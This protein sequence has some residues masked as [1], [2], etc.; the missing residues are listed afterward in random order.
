MG[1]SGERLGSRKGKAR[2]M[3][4]GWESSDG[5]EGHAQSGWNEYVLFF[6]VGLGGQRGNLHCNYTQL[7]ERENDNP[8]S[9]QTPFY[10]LIPRRTECEN[11][12]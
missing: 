12:A 8:H 9:V 5:C 2:G 3:K 11:K 1:R 4:H 6:Q 10:S 7:I